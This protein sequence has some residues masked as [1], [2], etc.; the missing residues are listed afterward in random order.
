MKLKKIEKDAEYRNLALHRAVYQ[1]GAHDLNLTAQLI[2]DGVVAS[3]Q[4]A[5][6]QVFTNGKPLPHNERKLTI[7]DSEWSRIPV[8]GAEATLSYL[9]SNMDIEADEI[10]V[11]G[12]VAYDQDK[13]FEH[14]S[15][16]CEVAGAKTYNYFLKSD[17]LPGRPRRRKVIND[18]NKQTEEATA[19]AREL[20][21]TFKLKG[22]RTFNSVKLTFKQNNAFYW[23]IK[24]VTF[25]RKGKAVRTIFPAQRFTSVWKAEKGSWAYVDLG[26][27]A[28]IE[29]VKLHWLDECSKG[30]IEISNDA[31]KWKPYVLVSNEAQADAKVQST[32]LKAQAL[33]LGPH[34]PMNP[35]LPSTH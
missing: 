11:E 14:Y 25:K 35:F 15:M 26:T 32:K 33:Y 30:V 7:N 23:S 20:K 1:L 4:P 6:L 5:F 12:F 17:T 2:T 3:N 10:V 19:M 13:P 29:E 22:K 9:W 28:D 34:K 31:K 16:H 18:P 8:E 27:V 24:E 21:E